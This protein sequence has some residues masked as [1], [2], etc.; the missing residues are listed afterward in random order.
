MRGVGALAAAVAVVLALSTGEGAAAVGSCPKGTVKASTSQWTAGKN[1]FV[2]D[3]LLI[4]RY[5]LEPTLSNQSRMYARVD[6]GLFQF[7]SYQGGLLNSNKGKASGS[8]AYAFK[9]GTQCVVK[10]TK[11]LTF[12]VVIR[13]RFSSTNHER[14]AF[15][16]MAH[17]EMKVP[18]ITRYVDPVTR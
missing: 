13:A 7:Y 17:V 6:A 18:R 3:F 15:S 2:G 10:K 12:Q 5:L 1:A 8:F 11:R 14:M 4:R 16:R 9:D